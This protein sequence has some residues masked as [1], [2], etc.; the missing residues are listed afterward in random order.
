MPL[1]TTFCAEHGSAMPNQTL[2]GSKLLLVLAGIV[3]LLFLGRA[4]SH[5]RVRRPLLGPGDYNLS[6]SFIPRGAYA[7]TRWMRK[8]DE[9]FS[10]GSQAG[11]DSKTGKFVSVPF[12]APAY[13]SCF[14]SGYPNHVGNALYLQA[15]GNSEKL[16]LSV[17]TDPGDLWREYSWTLPKAWKGR[18]V[19][20]VVEDQATTFQGWIALT[21]PWGESVSR[22]LVESF[23]RVLFMIS[24][25]SFEAGVFL[26]PGLAIAWWLQSRFRFDTIRFVSCMLVGSGA[27][28]Y[29]ALW[30]Y[31]LGQSIG[32]GVSLGIIVLSVC[33]LLHAG[34]RRPI[35]RNFLRAA[36]FCGALMILIT[37]FYSAIGFLYQRSPDPGIQAEE[38]FAWPMPADNILPNV[39][40][41][42][43]YNGKPF[44]P[45]LFIDWKS[46]DRPPLQ[47]AAVLLQRPLWL[48][49]QS[50]F[51]YQILGTFL[52]SMW[53]ASLWLLLETLAVGRKTAI[54]VFSF[55]LFSGFFILH[56]FFVWPKLLAAAFFIIAV[57]V[58]RF[59]EGGTE[60]C[61]LM[62][63]TIGC[64]AIGLAMLSHGGIAFSVIALA[65]FI[66]ARG[67]LPGVRVS[68]AGL[69]ALFA[70]LLPWS[71]YQKWYDPPGDRLLKWHLAGVI[72]RDNRS[73]RQAFI[74]AY[75]KVPVSKIVANKIA[76]VRTLI[77]P[78]PWE[79]LRH[80]RSSG[81]SQSKRLLQ[82]YKIGTFFFMFQM[83]GVLN[84]G[85]PAFLWARL[86]SGEL[87]QTPMVASLER[88][89]LLAIVSLAVWCA[90]I[91]I[92]GST[93]IHAGSYGT[94][95]L[96]FTALS[97]S[98]M[99]VIPKL[100]YVLLA[101]QAI[102]LFPLFAVT[103]AFLKSRPGT[104]F[105]GGADPGMACLAAVSLAVLAALVRWSRMLDWS[106]L[107][108]P[109]KATAPFHESAHLA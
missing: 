83:L 6:G 2:P 27:A 81:A 39:L 60:R 79:D 68:A 90:L 31:L 44:R 101:V 87:K 64:S 29:L 37:T 13:L 108:M 53:A 40:V 17:R 34:Y 102:F 82:W 80:A 33:A 12:A 43:L 58:L 45:F 95:M 78:G 51:D 65:V 85:F 67:R 41:D 66:L 89:V 36:L 15:E 38:R 57:V 24:T 48:S 5:D 71:A 62:D 32:K 28:G 35:E 49:K 9:Q 84:L 97:V 103:D 106:S 20:L 96:L 11:N 98:L 54:V 14:L 74:D 21:L 52:Q 56:S 3:L 69:A 86:F 7:G 46:S 73:F 42:D 105:A 19:R 22:S 72:D 50:K 25:I 88:L 10:L 92:P 63:T 77:G 93:V 100:T 23:S 94:V 109:E 76:N 26:V 18:Q 70:L 30:P 91:Y 1:I 59:P 107:V 75:T 16:N 55:C 99:T 104:V 47:S 61:D 4:V 8:E